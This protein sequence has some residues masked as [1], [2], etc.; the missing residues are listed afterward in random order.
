M[1]RPTKEVEYE[2]TNLPMPKARKNYKQ[3]LDSLSIGDG[4]IFSNPRDASNLR[5]FAYNKRI[6]VRGQKIMDK[7]CVKGYG[8]WR[9]S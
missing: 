5:T 3:I 6:H 8:V 4:V 7:N 1:S 2:R 9:V